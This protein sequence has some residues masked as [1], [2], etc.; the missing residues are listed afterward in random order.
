MFALVLIVF[1]SA[2]PCLE[3]RVEPTRGFDIFRVD[4]AGV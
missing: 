4:A 1:L 3:E 2:S